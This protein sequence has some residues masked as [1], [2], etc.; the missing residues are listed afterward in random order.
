MLTEMESG[1]DQVIKKAITR[2][3][4]DRNTDGVLMIHV[5]YAVSNN[6]KILV[7]YTSK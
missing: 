2:G 6:D 4:T 1:K 7:I 5:L 3:Q